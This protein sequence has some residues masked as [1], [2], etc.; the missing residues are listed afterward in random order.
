MNPHQTVTRLKR[1][2]TLDFAAD[3]NQ[4]IGTENIN[5]IVKTIILVVP[6]LTSTNTASITIKDEDGYQLY[7]ATGKAES[8]TH[9]LELTA[10]T[11]FPVAGEIS[12]T[13]DTSGVE[14]A[15]V[16]FVVVIYYQ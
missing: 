2:L 15:D 16:D 7:T 3:D 1:T 8:T 14:A 13:I 11:E 4:I 9:V 12:I 6:A 5:G 10:D